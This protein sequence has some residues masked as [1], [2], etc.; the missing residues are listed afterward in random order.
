MFLQKISLLLFFGITLNLAQA[1]PE[2]IPVGFTSI[3]NGKDLAGWH[4]SRTSHQGTTGNFYVENG[5]ITLK[6]RPYGQGG[7]LLTDRTYRNFELYLEAKIDS[8]CNGGIFL[9]SSES[10]MAYQIELA[11]PGGLGDLLGERMNVSKGAK[12][13]NIARVWKTNDWNAFRIRMEGDIP[14][15]RLWV[16]DE[17][18][19]DVTEPVNDFVAGATSGMIGLQAHWSAVY[20]KAAEAFEMSGSWKPDAAHRFRRIAIK[21][22]N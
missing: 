20:S 18:M 4:T 9:R 13:T 2:K 11:T 3:F 19:W 12:A 6:Q 16:N 21:E 1:Q 22:L 15:I 14:R 5:V 17:L 8:F 10:G 7:I